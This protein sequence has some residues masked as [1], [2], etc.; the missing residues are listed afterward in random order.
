MP[1]HYLYLVI[2]V[3]AETVG[4]TALQASNQFT[5]FWP[6]VL[7]VVA[8]AVAFYFLG[9]VLKYIP[10]GIAYAIWSGLGIVLIAL[11]G[12]AVFGQRL[13]GPALLGLGMIIS[14]IVVIQ[15]FSNAATH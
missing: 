7:V 10:V 12:F 2:A 15:L 11:I 1:L 13:D 8:Y 4:T 6:S 5:K 3:A 14:G 9:V